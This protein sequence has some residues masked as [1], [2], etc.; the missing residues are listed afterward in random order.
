MGE[1]AVFHVEERIFAKALEV[2]IRYGFGDAS[3]VWRGVV[4]GSGD[5]GGHGS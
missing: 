1:R 5:I 3:E 4:C 2:V